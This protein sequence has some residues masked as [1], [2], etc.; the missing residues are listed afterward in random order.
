MTSLSLV[1]IPLTEIGILTVLLYYF[2]SFFWNTRAM[3]VVIGFLAFILLF[4]FSKWLHL[5]VLEKILFHVVNVMVIAV[6][7]IF[8]PEFR[9]AL[10]KL[11]F[12]TRRQR[13]S[14][15][16]G[17]FIDSLINSI[18]RL[19]NHRIGALVVLENRHSLQ[20][21]AR[22]GVVLEA[23][24]SPE[25]LESIFS[26]NTPLHDGAVLI[27]GKTI[28]SAASI[29]PLAEDTSQLT[30]AMGTRHRA[31]LGMS[32][33]TDAL[34]LV[35]SEENGKVSVAR[36]GIMTRGIKEDRLK[37]VLRS[38]LSPITPTLRSGKKYKRRSG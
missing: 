2:L 18:Y 29:L 10:S 9:L 34:I 24:Y 28:I 30:R 23:R 27:R 36:E 3:D 8:Q 25:L 4:A 37:G 32:Q 7:I 1:L 5:T 15:E 21:W 38:V 17:Q 31:G 12:R 16:I 14:T 35:V 20:E 6:L 26:T 13:E 11:S 33:V 19:A 22:K